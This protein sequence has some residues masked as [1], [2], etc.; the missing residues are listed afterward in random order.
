MEKLGEFF[1][2]VKQ[3]LKLSTSMPFERFTPGERQAANSLVSRMIIKRRDEAW[4][5]FDEEDMERNAQK[6][7]NVTK[8]AETCENNCPGIFNCLRGKGFGDLVNPPMGY[9]EVVMALSPDWAGK[10]IIRTAMRPCSL[11]RDKRRLD[12]QERDAKK[13]KKGMGW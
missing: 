5:L 6:L 12:Q 11:L 7:I 1:D 13:G 8:S 2:G 4:D 3:A 9:Q 10:P